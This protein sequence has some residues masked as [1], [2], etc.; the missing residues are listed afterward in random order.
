MG[1][2]AVP[3]EQRE[4]PDDGEDKQPDAVP[5]RRERQRKPKDECDRQNHERCPDKV[6]AR[7]RTR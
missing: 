3:D 2:A 6:H 1:L 4:E 7:H 5:V